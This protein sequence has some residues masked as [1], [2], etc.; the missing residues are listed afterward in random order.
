M[1]SHLQQMNS[2][3]SHVSTSV[4][5][6]VANMCIVLHSRPHYGIWDR[7][8]NNTYRYIASTDRVGMAHSMAMA[9]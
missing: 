7:C 8:Y 4:S 5:T 6:T 1:I 3:S 9:N 2:Q